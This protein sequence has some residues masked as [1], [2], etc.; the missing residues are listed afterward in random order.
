MENDDLKIRWHEFANRVGAKKDINLIWEWLKQS[1]CN[2]DRFYHTFDHIRSCL[3][4]LDYLNTTHSLIGR[5]LIDIEFA[6][7]FHDIVYDTQ[8]TNNEEESINL[9]VNAYGVMRINNDYSKEN[10]IRMI[11]KSNHRIPTYDDPDKFDFST[12]AFLD[13]DLNILSERADIFDQ[14]ETN[15]RR[16][17]EWVPLDLYRSKR[18]EILESFLSRRKIYNTVFWGKDFE[19]QARKNITRSIQSLKQ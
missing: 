8:K 2:S 17:Y 6:I 12:L 7:W 16:E 4:S 13:I 19:I 10:I 14:Y 11:E 5:N 1:Y 3:N 9:F 15:I 18:S